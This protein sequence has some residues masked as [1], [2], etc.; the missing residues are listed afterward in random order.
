MIQ[1][2]HIWSE[3]PHSNPLIQ[4]NSIW[5][6]TF[7]KQVIIRDEF[8][9]SD[10]KRF[11]E[12]DFKRFQKSAKKCIQLPKK[13]C[14]CC[15]SISVISSGWKTWYTAKEN[16]NG[17]E[18]FFLCFYLDFTLNRLFRVSWYVACQRI[19]ATSDVQLNSPQQEAPS[20]SCWLN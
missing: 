17:P 9:K 10:F 19:Q 15:S 3:F 18:G 20:S 14:S 8:Q 7:S 16:K 11:Q 5:N 2:L 4:Y 13:N 6:I 1:I 12:S